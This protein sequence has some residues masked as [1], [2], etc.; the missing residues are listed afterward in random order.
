MGHVE[1]VE[2]GE[3][4]DGLELVYLVIR[5]PQLLEGLR[6]PLGAPWAG[7]AH[8]DP[9]QALHQVPPQRENLQ[10]FQNLRRRVP[11]VRILQPGHL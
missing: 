9:L 4:T 3:V 8:L 11:L 6:R 1:G 2:A 5:D 7:G 10:V